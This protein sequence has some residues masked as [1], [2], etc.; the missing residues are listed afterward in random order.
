VSVG[1]QS[2]TEIKQKVPLIIDNNENR[3]P[4]LR[5]ANVQQTTKPQATGWI[6]LKIEIMTIVI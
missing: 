2:C 1:K 6:T 5:R 3:A 4:T